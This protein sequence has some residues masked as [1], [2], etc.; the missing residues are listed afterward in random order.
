MSNATVVLSLGFATLLMLVMVAKLWLSHRQIRHVARHRG[1]VP[2]AF[3]D[4]VDLPSHQKA[5][6][7][8]I[9]KVRLDTVETALHFAM[10]LAWTLLGGLDALNQALLSWIPGGMTQQLLLLV[11]FG[12]VGAVTELPLSW[13]RTF[14]LEHRFGFNTS[15]LGQ[16][17][18]D[19]IKG[20]ALTLVLGV[21]LAALL[22]WVMGSTGTWWWAWCWAVYMGFSLLLMWAFPAFIAP[23]FNTF[24]PLADDALRTRVAALMQRC[25]FQASGFYVMDGSRRSAHANAYFTGLGKNKRVV[26]YDTLLKQLSPDE[27]EAVLAH[28]LGHFHHKHLTKRLITVS[29]TALLAFGILGWLASRTWF[30]T[31]LGIEP[32]LDAPNDA[33]ALILF[34]LVMPLVTFFA[35][36]VMSAASRRD[37]FEADGFAASHTRA[38]DLSSALL[39]LYQGNASTLTPDPT[40][41]S[42]YHSHP[43]ASQRLARLTP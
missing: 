26:F 31:G 13:Y 25:G 30:Y 28:E 2:T 15:S 23:L 12:A 42:F 3:A 41:V 38:S 5:A 35:A 10:L 17:L 14:V 18:M 6:D 39:K 11:S 1:A 34:M 8:T 19:G 4:T 9:A 43:P 29:M 36:P 32:S 24:Q 22:L 7:Y 40:Y 20:A 33:L 21:P 16:W 37:E 27:L